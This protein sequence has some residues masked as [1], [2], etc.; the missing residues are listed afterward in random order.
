MPMEKLEHTMP[1]HTTP[2][3]EEI[4][5]EK[6]PEPPADYLDNDQRFK[7]IIEDVALPPKVAC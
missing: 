6:V 1:A 3:P 7:S 5:K 4:E 2:K